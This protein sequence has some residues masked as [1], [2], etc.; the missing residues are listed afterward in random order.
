M[1]TKH[2]TAAAR[3]APRKMFYGWWIVAANAVITFWVAGTFFYSFGA[4]INPL[5]NAFGWST[6]QISLAFSIRSAEA[7][8]I[9]A[10]KCDPHKIEGFAEFTR[11]YYN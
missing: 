4:F 10:M 9:Q 6:A 1:D 8:S 5:K 7:G 2:G 3:A 11:R